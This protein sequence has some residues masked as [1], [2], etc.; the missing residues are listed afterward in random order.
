MHANVREILDRGDQPFNI[1]EEFSKLTPRRKVLVCDHLFSEGRIT[2]QQTVN[3]LWPEATTQ[4]MRT[5][6]KFLHTL[7]REAV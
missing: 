4:D 6:E 3:L 1:I 2:F 7:K 5:L